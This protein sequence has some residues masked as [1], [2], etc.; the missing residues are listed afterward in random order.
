MFVPSGWW[1]AVINVE[2]SIAITHNVVTEQNV[3]KSLEV[4]KIPSACDPSAC[5]GDAMGDVPLWVAMG[6]SAIR[7]PHPDAALPADN[8]GDADAAQIGNAQT[9]DTAPMH[10]TQTDA[11][12]ACEA[13]AKAEAPAEAEVSDARM[14]RCEFIRKG[15]VHRLETR[16]EENRPGLLAKLRQRRR[17]EEERQAAPSGLWATMKAP[18]DSV[19][20]GFSFGF[21]S[22]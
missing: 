19:D 20:S 13:S 11:D 14:C 17:A 15:M 18:A 9:T 2:E 22:S 4:L 8:Y 5:Q 7:P 21:G 12:E 10:S 1:H 16:L 6:G 3:L